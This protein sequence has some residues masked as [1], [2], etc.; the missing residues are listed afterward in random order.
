MCCETRNSKMLQ[1]P[2]AQRDHNHLTFTFRVFD[3]PFVVRATGLAVC[4]PCPYDRSATTHLT[5]GA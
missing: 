1:P 4:T 2:Q 3:S 5:G